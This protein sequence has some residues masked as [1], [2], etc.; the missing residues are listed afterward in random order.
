MD[1]FKASASAVPGELHPIYPQIPN[2]G[3]GFC[4]ARMPMVPITSSKIQASETQHGFVDPFD[5]N[6]MPTDPEHDYMD[7]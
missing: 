7:L 6:K 5:W 1:N 2:G 3:A 4:T